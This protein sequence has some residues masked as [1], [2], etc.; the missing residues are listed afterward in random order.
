MTT[1]RV[2]RHLPRG[3]DS[4]LTATLRSVLSA[5]IV[6]STKVTGTR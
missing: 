4:P 5:G 1:M 2:R 6:T 3:G